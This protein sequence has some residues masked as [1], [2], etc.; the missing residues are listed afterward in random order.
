[1]AS[2][3]I[4]YK[5]G[6]CF[7]PRWTGY[8]EIIRIA[9]RELKEIENGH[10][11]ADWLIM[12]IPATEDAD[13]IEMG[14]G[15]IDPRVGETVNRNLDLRSLTEENQRLFWKATQNARIKIA[16]AETDYSTI[17]SDL[18]NRYYQMFELSEKGE[19]PMELNDWR[20][21]AD[22]CTEKNGPGWD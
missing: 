6:R 8:D 22:P 11:L 1:M 13:V 17:S 3:F 19:P 5:D 4:V 12:Q 21:L 14:W 20:V 16:K 18:F 9:I 15:F 2:G 10:A 7:A